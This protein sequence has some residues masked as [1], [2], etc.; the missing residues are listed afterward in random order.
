MEIFDTFDCF[1]D[2]KSKLMNV[3]SLISCASSLGLDE[4]HPTILKVL[5][6][7][8]DELG[9]VD[10]ETF[11]NELTRRLGSARSREGRQTLFNLIDAEGKGELTVDDLRSLA[12]EVGHIITEEELKEVMDNISKGEPI[13][14]EEF[15]RYLARKLDR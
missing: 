2:P 13:T 10:F 15:E 1:V 3:T 8:S 9:E 4:K 6:S 5:Q 11:V 7:I 14:Y 12:K